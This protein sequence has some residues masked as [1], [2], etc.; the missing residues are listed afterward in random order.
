V[1]GV[2]FSKENATRL[3]AAGYSGSVLDTVRLIKDLRN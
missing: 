1:G 3:G 2:G